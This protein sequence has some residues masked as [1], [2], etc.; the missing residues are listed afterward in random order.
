[1]KSG[2]RVECQSQICGNVPCQLE[3]KSIKGGTAEV[4]CTAS[5]TSVGA[6]LKQEM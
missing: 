1:M 4:A 3:K 6:T 2:Q 5:V